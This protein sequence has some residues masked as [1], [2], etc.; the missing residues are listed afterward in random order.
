MNLHLRY[1]PTPENAAKHAQVA[2]DAVWNV[3]RLKLD[4]SPQSLAAADR[5]VGGFHAE[6]KKS[7][8]IQT[9]VFCFGC[10]FGEVFV[11]HHAA[12]WKMPADTDLSDEL[13]AG[14]NMMVIVTPN[15][16]IWNPIGKAFKLLENGEGESL[17]YMYHVATVR[18]C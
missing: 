12:V 13:K 1:P 5:I 6:G 9:L 18:G 15:G 7:D 10:Y 11:R 4:F 2:V 8:A 3:D 14:N 17:A 16:S